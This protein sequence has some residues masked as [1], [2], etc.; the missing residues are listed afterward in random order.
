MNCGAFLRGGVV[1]GMFG[2]RCFLRLQ[3]VFMSLMGVLQCLPGVFPPRQMI[4]FLVMLRGDTMSMRREIVKFSGS[5]MGVLHRC[6]G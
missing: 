5:P 1:V 2:R 3:R 4:L 6:S